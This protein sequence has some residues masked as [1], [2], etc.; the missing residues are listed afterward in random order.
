ME[1]VVKI[2]PTLCLIILFCGCLGTES[3]TS[4]GEKV[5]QEIPLALAS[6]SSQPSLSKK[7]RGNYSDPEEN[8]MKE[9]TV[10]PWNPER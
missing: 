10:Q 4:P 8:D 7:D 6:D 9:V 2:Y 3:Q 1:G 5:F